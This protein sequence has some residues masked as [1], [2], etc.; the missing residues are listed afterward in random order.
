MMGL[1]GIAAT[2][3]SRRE[4]KNLSQRALGAKSGLPQSH[5]SKIEGAADLQLSTLIELAR[6]LDLEV[7]LV[8][9]QLIPAISA[10]GRQMGKPPSDRHDEPEERRPMYALDPDEEP[11][12]RSGQVA[13]HRRTPRRTP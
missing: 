8:P 10:L 12:N 7:A 4:A 9:K 13:W 6:L 2:L 3:R 11:D 5:I 1:E